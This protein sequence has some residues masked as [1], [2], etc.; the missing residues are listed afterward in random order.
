M[1]PVSV[2]P[3]P[4]G[5]MQTNAFVLHREGSERCILIDPGADPAGL[6]HL[7]DNRNLEPELVLLT[8]SHFDH[9]GAVDGVLEH[10][11]GLEYRAHPL[12]AACVAD[13]AKNGSLFLLGMDI[14]CQAPT[15]FLDEG[16]TV[17]AA[18]ITLEAWFT[19]GHAP[20]HLVFLEREA[21][22]AVSGDTV[23]AGGVGRTDLP[24]CDPAAFRV[25]LERLCT[26]PD[27]T[28]FHPGHGPSLRL[29]DEKRTNPYLDPRLGA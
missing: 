27:D 3:V 28:V 17:E 8:H 21:G 7:L 14:R 10:W 6:L 11:P 4:L 2:L 24:G 19:P 12:C 23:F 26:L 16:D 1:K 29:G 25:T 22:L 5:P 9:I 13:P 18:G 20:G 15:D